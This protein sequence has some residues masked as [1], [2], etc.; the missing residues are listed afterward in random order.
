MLNGA[1]SRRQVLKGGT[2]L[3]L[4]ASS[5]GFPAVKVL[6]QSAVPKRKDIDSLSRA[7]LD[8]YAAAIKEVM[9][10]SEANRKDP[11]GYVFHAELHNKSR[12][13][14]DGSVGACEHNSEQFLPWHRAHLAG[15]EKVLRDIEADVTIPY[16][17]WT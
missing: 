11:T 4:A 1:F 10:R 15:F 5:S 12:D 16:W 3:C 8:R 7:E 17:D 9:R 2:A 6:S 14:P 13:H